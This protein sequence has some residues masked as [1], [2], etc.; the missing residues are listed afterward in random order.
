[1][2]FLRVLKE[3]INSINANRTRT[4]L[5]ILGIIIGVGAVIALM[6]IGQGAQQTITS[7]IESIGTNVAYIM[8]GNRLET[9]TNARSLN[10]ND[11]CQSNQQGRLRTFCTKHAERN[12]Q[13]NR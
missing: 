10:L 8:P 4:F 11:I 7:Q 12:C 2:K 13:C 3:A 1:M 5:T 9:V 6:A